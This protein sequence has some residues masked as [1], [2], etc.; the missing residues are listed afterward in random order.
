MQIS[1]KILNDKKNSG[2]GNPPTPP[3]SAGQTLMGG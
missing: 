2:R 1:K 3:A